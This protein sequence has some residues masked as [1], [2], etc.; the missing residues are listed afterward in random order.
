MGC[1]RGRVV[2]LRM[3]R[4][5]ERAGWVVMGYPYGWIFWSRIYRLGAWLHNI[6]NLK[7]L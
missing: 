7:R 2:F 4:L 6:R 3:L 1:G 5:L